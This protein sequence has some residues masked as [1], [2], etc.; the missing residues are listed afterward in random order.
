MI[1]YRL[2]NTLTDNGSV[3]RGV[4]MTK[5]GYLSEI[6][7]RTKIYKTTEGG[8][9]EDENGQTIELPAD[10]VVSMNFWCL[11]PLCLPVQRNISRN[12]WK[13]PPEIL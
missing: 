9:F 4:C 1:G 13:I 11:R 10:T 6:V 12:F 2:G 5:D 7:E 8:R 3:A